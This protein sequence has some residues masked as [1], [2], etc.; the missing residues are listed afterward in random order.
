MYGYHTDKDSLYIVLEYIEEGNLWE[1]MNRRKL[2]NKEIFKIFY[3]VVSAM[4][5]IHQK[6]ILHRD[7]KPENILITK[8]KDVKLCDFG[9]CAPFGEG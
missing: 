3:Q 5:Y 6:N 9:F 2:Q 4:C 1:L 8:K 7:I